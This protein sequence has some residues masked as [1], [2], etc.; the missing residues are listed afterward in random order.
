ME[1]CQL[2]LELLP[3]TFAV[4]KVNDL[5]QVDWHLPYCFAGHTDTECSLVCREQDVPENAI[6]IEY[7]WRCF[8]IQGMLDFSLVGILADLSKVLADAGIAIFAISTYDTDHILVSA[9][10]CDQAQQALRAAGYA[11]K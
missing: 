8:R 2:H 11:M 6:K 7:G 5:T 1:R 10:Q 3:E 4:C 9:K